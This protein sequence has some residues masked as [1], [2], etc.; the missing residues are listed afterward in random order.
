MLCCVVLCC[1]VLCCAVLCCAV[2]CCVVLCCA[3]SCSVVL[4][5]VVFCCAVLCRDVLGCVVLCCVVS[6]CAVLCPLVLHNLK[7]RCSLHVQYILRPFRFT[8]HC[9]RLTNYHRLTFCFVL[10]SQLDVSP[11][12]VFVVICITLNDTNLYNTGNEN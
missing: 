12:F 10:F 8:S 1:V 6:C 11:L 2:L 3:V 7:V 4:C 9:N 5:C